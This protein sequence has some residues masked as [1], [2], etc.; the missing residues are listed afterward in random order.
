MKTALISGS[1]GFIGKRLLFRLSSMDIEIVPLERYLLS[2]HIALKNF[3][4]KVQPDYI[5]HL[6]GYGN[7][8]NQQDEKEILI[9]NISN[10]FNLLQATKELNY[11]S[12]IN[13][14]TSSVLLPTQTFYSATKLSGELIAKVFAEKY[15]KPIINI[16]PSSVYGEN[17]A[18]FR[19]IPKVINSL[20][21]NKKI[22]VVLEPKHDWI[23]I[24][25]FIYGM[26]TFIDHGQNL[27]GQSV[28][29]STGKQYSNE[30]VI[31]I[32]ENIH[33][34]KL[35]CNV[36][37]NLRS[38]DTVNWEVDNTVLKSL[39]WEPTITFEEGLKR[40]YNYLKA[41]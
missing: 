4:N 13:I 12:L 28:N 11:K 2:T 19:F 17:E 34:S 8:Y 26:L 1:N 16:R 10:L 37:N 35:N 23:Y 38:Y 22:D 14:S 24:D 20:L 32:L 18:D 6:A 29:V 40:V 27:R 33:G 9:A 3:I 39:N 36:T 5:F 25:D 31:N 7:H 41:K 30:E 15:N 21:T